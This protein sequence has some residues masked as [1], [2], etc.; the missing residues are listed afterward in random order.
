VQ[1][2]LKKPMWEGDIDVP[3]TI[4]SDAWTASL[5]SGGWADAGVP[6][7]EFAAV[8]RRVHAATLK[9]REAGWPP[10]FVFMSDEAW[11]LAAH[12]QKVVGGLLTRAD[13]GTEA[14]HF[15]WHLEPSFAAFLLD[16]GHDNFN[17]KRAGNNFP[18]PHRDHCYSMA[19]D[20]QGRRK[21]ISVWMPI[22]DVEVDSGCMYV[23][24]R[25]FDPGFTSDAA[26]HHMALLYQAKHDVAEQSDDTKRDMVKSHENYHTW[27]SFGWCKTTSLPVWNTFVLECKPDPLGFFL[28]E[29]CSYSPCI[30]CICSP[31]MWRTR[32]HDVCAGH[33]SFS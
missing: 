33:R 6:S 16:A 28:P 14:E 24:P 4:N 17:G 20:S 2:F 27:I 18:L 19:F 22:T 32:K 15:S 23:V 9:L 3:T 10:A 25:E 13:Q 11:W 31:S 21:L 29:W 26:Y 8:A 1:A 30:S 7:Q 5:E 12:V